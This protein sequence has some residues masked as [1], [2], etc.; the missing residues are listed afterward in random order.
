[1][2][3][4]NYK[5]F[6]AAVIYN[7]KDLKEAQE[8]VKLLRNQKLRVWFA[9]DGIKFGEP[10]ATA[11]GRA[12]RNTHYVLACIGPSGTSNY[13]AHFELSSA[14]SMASSLSINLV[15]IYLG[16]NSRYSPEN[17][18]E[19]LL[20]G[21]R[22]V[23]FR[24]HLET[25]D[26]FPALVREL[27]KNSRS[28][29][30]TSVKAA[31]VK[32]KPADEQSS[33]VLIKD[34]TS[35]LAAI[36][37]GQLIDRGLNIGIGAH[38][39]E[40]VVPDSEDLSLEIVRKT[41]N[42]D[43]SMKLDKATHDQFRRAP[44]L[45]PEAA[46]LAYSLARNYEDLAPSRLTEKFIAPRSLGEPQAFRS[47]AQLMQTVGQLSWSRISR[48]VVFTTNVDCSLERSFIK[49]GIPFV[50]IVFDL[51]S[52]H[53]RR[54]EFAGA[55]ERDGAYELPGGSTEFVARPLDQISADRRRSYEYEFGE[56]HDQYMRQI[57]G[58][59]A[60][61]I[62]DLFAKFVLTVEINNIIRDYDDQFGKNRDQISRSSV[63]ELPVLAKLLGSHLVGSS[64]VVSCEQH[65]QLA[66][67]ANNLS[68]DV[69]EVISHN[70]NVLAGYC[71]FDPVFR[72]LFETILREP[73]RSAR[74]SHRYALLP[75]TDNSM[76]GHGALRHVVQNRIAGKILQ[77]FQMGLYA[78]ISP[79]KFFE[80]A[81]KAVEKRK[82]GEWSGDAAERGLNP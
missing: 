20:Q 13:F 68:A 28:M 1:M 53:F 4:R 9:K 33:H 67:L 6:G 18:P 37:A 72:L 80:Q 30:G 46:A 60:R 26:E 76:E 10:I 3:Q 39:P 16:K 63:P 24:Y 21:V 69:S 27:K 29:K 73:F 57:D 2:A 7:S 49:E 12:F 74:H 11:I 54:T 59:S 17:P 52:G 55:R 22:S 81:R 61:E 42:L 23:D 77:E 79:G 15:P 50:R 5:E 78:G 44:L 32:A 64:A 34:Q 40:R 38:W 58:E 25:H 62:E 45:A 65:Y 70:V 8:L 56:N 71:V 66:C 41:L 51:A 82:R 14:I 47:L 31:N 48:A 75:E 36:V 43:S 35:E 19:E